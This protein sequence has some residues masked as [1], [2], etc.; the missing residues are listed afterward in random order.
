MDGQR[1]FLLPQ[2]NELPEYVQLPSPMDDPVYQAFGGALFFVIVPF[3][4]LSSTS[5]GGD[6]WAYIRRKHP[7]DSCAFLLVDHCLPLFYSMLLS[8]GKI[9]SSV[10]T[11][12]RLRLLPER[13]GPTPV[14]P[15]N[16]CPETFSIRDLISLRGTFLIRNV[17]IVL[18]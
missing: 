11:S 10:Y 9:H 13:Q 6:G 4:H 7:S 18:Q 17:A 8:C 14:V 3:R 5:Q 16:I 2:L 12:S 15:L 1:A